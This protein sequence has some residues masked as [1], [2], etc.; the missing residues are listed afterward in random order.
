[1]RSWAYDWALSQQPASSQSAPKR[2]SYFAFAPEAGGQ[3]TDSSSG[4]DR[5]NNHR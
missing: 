1:V 3:C 2:R 4:A 5:T